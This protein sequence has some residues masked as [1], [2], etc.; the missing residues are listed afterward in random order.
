[1]LV[2]DRSAR[3]RAL[4]VVQV[5]HTTARKSTHARTC[6]AHQR[7]KRSSSPANGKANKQRASE[8]ATPTHDCSVTLTGGRGNAPTRLTN[9]DAIHP[10]FHPSIRPLMHLSVHPSICPSIHPSIHPSVH[11]SIHQPTHTSTYPLVLTTMYPSP[12][13]RDTR[14]RAYFSAAQKH[15]EVVKLVV[16]HPGVSRPVM[17][18]SV[19]SFVRSFVRSF[20]HSPFFS[21]VAVRWSVIRVGEST[22]LMM[23]ANMHPRQRV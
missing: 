12:S 4:N 2:Q 10:S 21:V 22:T 15:V 16:V 11:L 3:V 6:S 13:T 1:M 7:A 20:I 8:R 19:C 23:Q 9:T 17:A 14:P 18:S 5:S